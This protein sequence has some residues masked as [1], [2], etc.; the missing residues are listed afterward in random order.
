MRRKVQPFCLSLLLFVLP[1]VHG[2]WLPW[3]RFLCCT[4]GSRNRTY[5]QAEFQGRRNFLL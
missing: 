3:F 2:L 5:G 4:L 1:A